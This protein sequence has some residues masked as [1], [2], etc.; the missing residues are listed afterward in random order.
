MNENKS[1]FAVDMQLGYSRKSA[2][3]RGKKYRITILSDVLI[4]FEYSETGKF[5]DF[6]T[7]F[8][9]NRKFETPHFSVQEDNYYIIITGKYFKIEA[10]KSRPFRSTNK[11]MPDT[12]LRVTL[13]NTDKVWYVDHPEARNF[14]GTAFSYDNSKIDLSKGL[15]S[16]DGFASFDDT[17]TPVLDR[18]G[19][20]LK[21]PINDGFDIY[22]FIYRKDFN[23]ALK[24]YYDLTGYPSFIPRYALGLWWQKN[25]DYTLNGIR[26]LVD[27]FKL[28]KI[29]ISTILLN[30][31]WHKSFSETGI[32]GF[33]FNNEMLG[34]K[35]AFIKY[36]HDNN[37]FLG[38]NLNT[39]EG[40]NPAEESYEN[41][42]KEIGQSDK[43]TIILNV[44]N[45]K[46][47]DAF[48]KNIINPFISSGIDLFWLDENNPL[49][50]MRLYILNS[51]LFNNYKTIPQRRGII[52]SRNPGISPHRF[53]VLYSGET[54]VSWKTLKNLPYL[55]NSATNLGVTWWSHDI[56]GYKSGIEDAEL[57]T[58]YVQ[59]GVYSPVFRFSADKSKYYKREPWKWDVKTIGI[60]REYTK[61]R[62]KLIPYIYT[63]AY[64]YSKVGDQLIE[65]LYYKY[66]EIIDEPLYRDEYYFGS[67]LF[68]SPI[69]EQK[70]RVMNRVVHKIFV[71]DGMWYDFKTGKKFPGGKRYVTFYKDEDYP[72]YAKSGSILIM[73]DVDDN[74]LN[75]TRPPR[76]LE[77]Q[78][79]P[80][81]SNSYNL[82][83]DDGISSLYEEGYYIITA[84]DYN[85][86]E[87][88]YTL[89]IRPI[90][91]KSGIIPAKR[92][93]KIKFRNTKYAEEVEV[94]V[95]EYKM[96]FKKYVEGSDFILE[97]E[98]VSTISQITVNCKGKDIEID[99]VRLINEEIDN[100]ISDLQI[101]TNLKEDIAKIIFS[102]MELKK[103]RI[104]IKKLRAKGLQSI[105]IRMFV[106]LLEYIAE[107]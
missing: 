48:L 93:Y 44:Y 89:I 57:Y 38:L 61:L 95:D 9:R 83:E 5:N 96:P 43:A 76:K 84:F 49:D 59:L 68:V 90:D 37:I 67:E 105:F 25:E 47:V 80:G 55:Y 86:R 26:N 30:K 77:V 56:G 22:L 20:I 75:N 53:P 19:N 69:T 15:Y 32:G 21:N 4:R 11:L 103:K 87:N 54:K 66:P 2:Q 63:E 52:F 41:I 13:N 100:I 50:S 92:D 71:P 6:P 14:K 91:G 27:E 3:I 45:R 73:A 64:K 10:S 97:F 31:G 85:Y 39:S 62:H 16:T 99:A 18:N 12:G 74:D 8:A 94:F 34:N 88:N 70:D 107:I 35:E 106:K 51:F 33:T 1:P 98:N 29:P 36:M 7:L 58:R 24:S 101:D 23:L 28:N 65:P 40:L 60:V 42:S 81:R 102:D 79:F 78:I 46:I 104:E 82:Y 17:K 72:V